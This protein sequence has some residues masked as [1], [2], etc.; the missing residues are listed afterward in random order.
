MVGYQAAMPQGR[1]MPMMDYIL[2]VKTLMAGA[3]LICLWFM[4]RGLI[5]MQRINTADKDV[6]ELKATVR[7]LTFLGHDWDA[8]LTLNVDDDVVHVS[9]RLPGSWFGR[10]TRQVTDWV[11][12]YWRR[13][14]KQAVAE[15]TLR[16][17]QRAFLVGFVGIALT[18]LLYVLLF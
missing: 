16:Y 2:A 10:K 12:V 11:R 4:V 18:A 7:Q 15:E 8:V 1:N 5:D 17:G 3:V 9:C 14:D 13:G 6:L